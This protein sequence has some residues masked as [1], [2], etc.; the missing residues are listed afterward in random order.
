LPP[1][2]SKMIMVQAIDISA[3]MLTGEIPSS[4]GSCKVLNY[5]NLSYNAL[6]DLI[7]VPL[8]KLQ[9]LQ[10]MDFSFNK[11]SG[12]VPK[13]GG[14]KNLGAAAFI[15]N[16][17]L[18]G[19]WV[20]LPPCSGNRHKS[21]SLLERVIMPAVAVTAIIV[22]CLFLGVLRRS[23]N[24]KKPVLKVGTQVFHMENSSLEEVYLMRPTC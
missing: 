6:E 7:P 15:G 9:N 4:L 2:L 12:E 20:S 22:L 11:L 24:R 23:Q 19:S 10:D 18:C 13:G 5:L 17:G 21:H 3:N 16:I 14:F 1:E 8:G